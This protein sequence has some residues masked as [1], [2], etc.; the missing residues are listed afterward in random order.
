MVESENHQPDDEKPQPE[1]PSEG[2][3]S[4]DERVSEAREKAKELGLESQPP[5]P[6]SV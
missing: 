1:N 4:A 2:D 6:K 3:M 5:E